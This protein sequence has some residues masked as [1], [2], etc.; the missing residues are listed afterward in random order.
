VGGE[1]IF[2]KKILVITDMDSVGSGY[3]HICVP[4]FTELMKL[5]DYEIKV[6]GMMYQGQEHNYP[7]S[8]VP[9]VVFEEAIG[10]AH[11]LIQ[12]WFPDVVLVAMDLP[13]QQKVSEMLSPLMR[14]TPPEIEQGLT[15]SRKYIA[16]TPLESGPLVL[17]WAMPLVNMDAVFFISQLGADEA[18]KVGIKAEHLQVGCDTVLWHPATP[19]EKKQFRDGLGIPQDAFVVLTVADN[20]ERKNLWY[21]M[22]SIVELKKLTE[23]PIRYI[24]VT[25]EQNPYGGK[26]RSGATELGI[27]KELVIYERGMSQKDLWALYAI[28]DAYLQPSKAEGLGLPVLDAMCMKIPVVAT[29][30][31]AMTELLQDGR[32]FLVGGFEFRDVWG[33]SRRVIINQDIVAAHLEGVSGNSWETEIVDRAYEYVSKRTW[34]IPAKQLH[35]KIQE[36]FE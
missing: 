33:N 28:S 16:I 30:V 29:D 10:A 3:K 15:D 24:L 18:Q 5:D 26:L 4:L 31:G 19:E 2:M 21:G 8:V 36:I 6:I 7:F 11:N 17:D 25:R 12:I 1:N 32:G 34:D 23:R 13:L 20:Q 22:E 14:R 35:N 27:N 9:T